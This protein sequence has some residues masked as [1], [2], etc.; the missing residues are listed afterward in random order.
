M[1]CILC[2]CGH[3]AGLNRI[4]RKLETLEPPWRRYGGSQTRSFVARPYASVKPYHRV[5][6]SI[7]WP[8]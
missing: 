8:N 4:I 3:L 5:A 2:E 6:K 7:E 1:A